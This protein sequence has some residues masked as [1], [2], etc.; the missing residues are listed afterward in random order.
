MD[1]DT[2]YIK[3]KSNPDLDGEWV[4]G[5][6]NGTEDD[7]EYAERIIRFRN[8]RFYQHQQSVVLGCSLRSNSWDW[9]VYTDGMYAYDSLTFS[10]PLWWDWRY[11]SYGW[12]WNYGWG[13]DRPYYAWGIFSGLLGRLGM[14]ATGVAGMAADLLGSSSTT[15]RV[16]FSWGLGR[17]WKVVGEVPDVV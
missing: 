7:Y 4:T 17:R 15:G 6:F 16:W 3:E 13:W 2:L 9:N 10:N 14:A 5:E 8:P 11:G 12:G 1:N